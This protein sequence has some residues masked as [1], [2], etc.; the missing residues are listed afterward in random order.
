MSF[1]FKIH[2]VTTVGSKWQIVIPKSA[3]DALDINYG[4]DVMLISHAHKWLMIMKTSQIEQTKDFVN[5]LNDE[6]K[7]HKKN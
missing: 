3:R 2:G 4:D 6:I 1:D 7:K 5:M